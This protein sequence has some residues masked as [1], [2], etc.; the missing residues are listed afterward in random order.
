MGLFIFLTIG[1]ALQFISINKKPAHWLVLYLFT[2]FN[3][4]ILLGLL[5][6]KRIFLPESIYMLCI[7]SILSMNYGVAIVGSPC[8]IS[9]LIF[10]AY[11]VIIS[12][13]NL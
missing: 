13:L 7:A 6:V 5:K 2:V 11:K 1:N 10:L 9:G 12:H 3:K 4:K 8:R